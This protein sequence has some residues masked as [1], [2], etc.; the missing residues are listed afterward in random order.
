MEHDVNKSAH[1]VKHGAVTS[2]TAAPRA[3][4]SGT[5]TPDGVDLKKSFL[6]SR[7]EVMRSATEGFS[8]EQLSNVAQ[9]LASLDCEKF[10]KAHP[11]FPAFNE[12]MYIRGGIEEV[13][14]PGYN[15]Y[16]LYT[17]MFSDPVPAVTRAVD[18][19]TK[20]CAAH[21]E[22]SLAQVTLGQFEELRG[23]RES[24]NRRLYQ[25]LVN[26]SKGVKN[27]DAMLLWAQLAQICNFDGWITATFGIPTPVKSEVEASTETTRST[28]T[29]AA[30][31]SAA[32]SSKLAG[33]I[34]TLPKLRQIAFLAA[35][36]SAVLQLLMLLRGISY[37]IP[38]IAA[39]LLAYLIMKGNDLSEGSKF[40]A[41]PK[42]LTAAMGVVSIITVFRWWHPPVLFLLPTLLAVALAAVLW[43]TVLGRMK[44]RRGAGLLLLALLAVEMLMTLLFGGR[45]SFSSFIAMLAALAFDFAYLV[46]A[47]LTYK[48]A[49]KGN[50]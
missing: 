31:E 38:V 15:N 10:A 30:A 19:M 20:W 49:L 9:S 33:Q 37:V 46:I 23:D 45:G 17:N 22:D 32:S 41:V 48:D 11:D 13:G 2:G 44:D 14:T 5:V 50:G 36:G 35:A 16:A 8:Y 29:A 3:V 43:M 26:E 47:Y 34:R 40:M 28:G 4:A 21:P 24:V 7:I 39:A 6:Y 1:R 25:V 42:T 27:D 12:L 18:E